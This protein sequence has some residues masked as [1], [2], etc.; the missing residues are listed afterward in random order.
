MSSSDKIFVDLNEDIVFILEKIRNSASDR[1]ILMV[2]S[3]ANIASSLISMKIL[4]RQITKIPK[5]IAIVTD[6]TYALK[7]AEKANIMA[8]SEVSQIDAE[9]W[10]KAKIMKEEITNQQE[11]I[12]RQLLEKRSEK[13]VDGKS[14]KIV[15]DEEIV[16]QPQAKAEEDVPRVRKSRIPAKEINIGGMMFYTAGD[17][18]DNEELLNTV[19]PKNVAIDNENIEDENNVD[20]DQFVDTDDVSE[21]PELE[22]EEE[23]E[24][25]VVPVVAP[26][27]QK[28]QKDYS[29]GS[30]NKI[31]SRDVKKDSPLVGKNLANAYAA[32][33]PKRRAGASNNAAPNQT[34]ES[35]KTTVS[36]LSQKF[37]SSDGDSKKKILLGAGGLILAFFVISYLF[38]TSVTVRV[39]LKKDTVSVAQTVKADSASQQINVSAATIPAQVRTADDD[40]SESANATGTGTKGDKAQGQITL[41]NFKMTPQT[42]KAGTIVTIQPSGLKYALNNAATIPAAVMVGP[43][44]TPGVSEDLPITATSHGSNYNSDANKSFSIEGYS[45]DSNGMTGKNFTPIA[46]GTSVQ[47]TVVSQDDIDSVKEIITKRVESTVVSKLQ[48]LAGV[49]EMMLPNSMKVEIVKESTTKKVGDEAEKFDMSIQAKASAYFVKKSDVENLAK[50]LAKQKQ[51]IAGDSEINIAQFPK[52]ENVVVENNVATFSITT[53]ASARAKITQETIREEIEGKSMGEAE[54]YFKDQADIESYD[55]SYSPGYIPGFLRRV[56]AGDKLTI[57]ISK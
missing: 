48:S 18:V 41:Y 14:Y 31:K 20:L 13:E 50:E 1:V 51:E 2:P 12:K 16:A 35:I 38:M 10:D 42:I 54:S 8:V 17:I 29:N 55:L 32:S 47:T 4:A 23:I 24:E 28:S 7:Q 49:D 37:L 57:R 33:L 27:V 43:A 11:R 22:S 46:G 36:D 56:P 52:I 25:E 44:V 53:E 19:L 21:E 6:D 40:S 5:L 3:S 15:D 39:T 9:V 26:P 45:Y 30:E 34:I